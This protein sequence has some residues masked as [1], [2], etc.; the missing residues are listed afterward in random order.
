MLQ[1]N[2]EIF[3]NLSGSACSINHWEIIS[4]FIFLKYPVF[5]SFRGFAYFFILFRACNKAAKSESGIEKRED[6]FDIS[7]NKC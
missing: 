3:M 1:F 7:N 2:K 4:G 6:P 5:L